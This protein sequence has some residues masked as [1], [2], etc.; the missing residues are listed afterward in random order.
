M[1]TKINYT[2]L[3]QTLDFLNGNFLI[4]IIDFI[5]WT[6]IMIHKVQHLRKV[7]KIL[8]HFPKIHKIVT[9]FLGLETYMNAILYANVFQTI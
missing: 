2:K 1:M 7:Y 6:H 3:K 9:K 4:Q 8:K 5:I